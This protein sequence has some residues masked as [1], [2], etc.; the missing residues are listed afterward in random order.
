MRAPV[1][2]SQ[3]P[4][5]RES[6]RPN[7]RNKDFSGMYSSGSDAPGDSALFS[8][9]PAEPPTRPRP[10][11]SPPR[12]PRVAATPPRPR[13]STPPRPRV[14]FRLRPRPRPRTSVSAAP[15]DPYKPSRNVSWAAV[16]DLSVGS[17]FRRSDWLRL[18]VP[19]LIRDVNLVGGG[20]L[21]TFWS[22]P[23]WWDTHSGNLPEK[24]ADNHV[25]IGLHDGFLT[26]IAVPS[27]SSESDEPDMGD[28]GLPPAPDRQAFASSDASESFESRSS[29]SSMNEAG[30]K[31]WRGG[32]LGGGAESGVE[33]IPVRMTIPIRCKKT[34]SASCSTTS[35][36]R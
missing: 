2:P 16:K 15:V 30:S 14:P 27:S 29:K 12:A 28:A 26:R 6:R 3:L 32:R 1:I 31:R 36:L 22:A 8:A 9:C 13:I 7:S 34:R 4:R 10:L 17:G 23:R 33:N 24:S 11:S 21:A 19:R 25:G 35:S 20:V 5:R 18:H